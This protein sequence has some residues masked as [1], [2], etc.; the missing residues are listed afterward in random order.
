MED[1]DIYNIVTL[2]NIDDEEFVF[3]VDKQKYIIPAGETRKFPKFMAQL[4]IK[5]LVDKILQKEDPEGK[6][7]TNEAKRDEIVSKILIAEQGYEQ[8][9][10]PTDADIVADMNKPSDI[11]RL[12]KK[13]KASLK[14][15]ETSVTEVKK[16]KED[17]FDGLEES[18]GIPNR[19]EMISYAKVTMKMN[20]DTIID[21]GEN[22]GSTIQQV[23]DKMT[24]AELYKE[25][26]ME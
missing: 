2:K 8:P 26:G 24:D 18:E 5:H 12:L 3:S 20:L 22:K 23:Y 14:E 13:N 7:L 17:K 6:T 25:L 21:K 1:V 4:A 16:E 19:E 10:V 15:R 11:D 9:K